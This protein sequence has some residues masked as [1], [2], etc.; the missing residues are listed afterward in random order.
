MFFIVLCVL[1]DVERFFIP[2]GFQTVAG[3]KRSATTGSLVP[4]DVSRRDYRNRS[5]LH[6]SGMPGR[7]TPVFRWWRCAYHRLLSEIP[8]G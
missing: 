5:C 3:G 2:K 4:I 7:R 6:P 1:H 8:P